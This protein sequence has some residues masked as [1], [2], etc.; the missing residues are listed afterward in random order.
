MKNNISKHITHKEATRSHT[1]I[2]LGIDNSPT[3]TELA[4]MQLVAAKVFEPLRDWVANPIKVES[5][6]RCEKLNFAVGGSTNSQHR[7]GQAI[8][9][10]DDYNHKTNSE[11]FYWI[12]DNLKFDQIIWE[13]GN[14]DNPGWIH[15]SYTSNNRNRIS[16]AYKDDGYTKYKHFTDVTLFNNFKNTITDKN[17]QI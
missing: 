13:F 1:A 5:F 15:I 4:N 14:M 3:D 2:Q 11:M 6:F 12:L 16:I 17:K 9:I 10:D 7:F 8:D